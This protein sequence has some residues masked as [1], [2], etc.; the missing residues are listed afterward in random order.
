M[1]MRVYIN[2]SVVGSYVDVVYIRQTIYF[3]GKVFFSAF[4][5]NSIMLFKSD[6]PTYVQGQEHVILD[7]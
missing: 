7:T 1:C 6:V 5:G 4:V 2:I 3:T